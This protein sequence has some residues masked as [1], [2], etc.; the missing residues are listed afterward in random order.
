MDQVR[1]AGLAL[2]LLGVAGYVLGVLAPYAGRS[3]SLVGIM[4][5]VTL[6]VVGRGSG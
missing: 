2:S 1:Q 3:V 6:L 4:V 5:G